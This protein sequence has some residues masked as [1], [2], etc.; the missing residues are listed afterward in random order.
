[1]FHMVKVVLKAQERRVLRVYR[2]SD[3]H[4]DIDKCVMCF[5]QV[6]IF[7]E[8]LHL[9]F[10]SVLSCTTSRIILDFCNC[11]YC[12]TISYRWYVFTLLIQRKFL[13]V[14]YTF[15]LWYSFR[16]NMYKHFHITLVLL[17]FS[18]LLSNWSGVSM[19]T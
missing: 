6:Y 15:I 5:W 19:L 3:I 17:F 11:R 1:M 4:D 14:H 8:Y 18:V 12:R 7:N 9:H 16:K 2:F 10:F 13:Y